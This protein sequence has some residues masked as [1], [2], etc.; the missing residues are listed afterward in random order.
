MSDTATV[1]QNSAQ[2]ADDKTAEQTAEVNQNS[3]IKDNGTEDVADESVSPNKKLKLS[4]DINEDS[5]PSVTPASG[6]RGRPAKGSAK[7]LNIWEKT[8]KEG[9]ALLQNL[10]H[11]GGDENPDGNRRT[12]RSQTRGTPPAAAPTPPKRAAPKSPSKDSGSGT[13]KR[14]GRP[15]K[16]SV[17]SNNSIDEKSEVEANNSETKVDGNDV[18]S[19]QEK[20]EVNNTS[21]S[22]TTNDSTASQPQANNSTEPEVTTTDE[23]KVV[24]NEQTNDVKNKANSKS[25]DTSKANPVLKETTQSSPTSE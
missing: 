23:P 12:T 9:E 19:S 20:V 14:R 3:V 2:P 18:T 17:S 25:D 22:K 1:T 15:P 16:N 21:E 5:K 13:P 10:G 11:K 7:R 8:A 4:N 6:G 24:P